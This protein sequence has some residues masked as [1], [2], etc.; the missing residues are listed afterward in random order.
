MIRPKR[1][2]N[3][4]PAQ[5]L[6]EFALIA[7]LLLT[8]IFIVIEGARY[9]WAW[10]SVQNA[11]REAARYAIT[12]GTELDCYTDQPHRYDFLCDQETLRV[13][14]I[15]D[16]AHGALSGLP[17]NEEHG[18]FDAESYVDDD[19]IYYGNSYDIDIFGMSDDVD[20]WQRYFAGGPQQWVNVSVYYRMP[21]IVPLLGEERSTLS[22]KG[23]TTLLNE[24][25][26]RLANAE[27]GVG[28]PPDIGEPIPTPG[29][30][31]SPTPSPSPTPTGT[32]GP[33]ATP[34][35]TPTEVPTDEPAICPVQFEGDAIAGNTYVFITGEVGSVVTIVDADTGI[36]LGSATLIAR[37][38]HLCAGFA[39]FQQP[40]HNALIE[41]LTEGHLLVASS[42]DG[43]QDETFVI[44]QPPTGTATATPTNTVQPTPSSTPTAT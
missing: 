27:Q 36:T 41:A 2:K 7:T 26:G 19:P 15:F 32:P 31:P 6:V 12:G 21:L 42:S 40:L 43:S 8:L 34:T 3:A 1:L 24:P 5:A 13:S 37:D 25:F 10:N 11:S 18:V 35:D 33:T 38:G 30:T 44:G 22:I 9:L 23:S 29:P 4:S 16:V 14:S 28:L 17:L 20:G 39:D